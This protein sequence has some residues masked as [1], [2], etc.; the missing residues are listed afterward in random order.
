MSEFLPTPVEKA[1][2]AFGAILRV[3]QTGGKQGQVA[4]AI[5]VSD[6]TMHRL[7]NEQMERCVQALYHAGFKVVPQDMKCYPSQ[8]VEAWYAAYKRQIEHSETAEKL[9]EGIE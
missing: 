3:L 2:K 8:D 5:G 9:F 1:R 7:V 4:V 6:T